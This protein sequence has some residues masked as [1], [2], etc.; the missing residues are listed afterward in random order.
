MPPIRW[1]ARAIASELISR[2]G[3]LDPTDK[4][5]TNRQ[6]V[7][8]DFQRSIGASSIRATGFLLRNSL[9]LIL[10]LHLFSRRPAE[11]RPIR[12]GGTADCGGGTAHISAIGA[13]LRAAHR[14]RRRSTTPARLARSCRSLSHRC[15][16]ADCRQPVKTTSIRRWS[17]CM[18]RARSS[19][20]GSS[21][22]R[23]VCEPTSTSSPSPR[24]TR[25]TPAMAP[26]D[27]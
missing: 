21:A 26:T 19:G 5:T 18:R 3:T 16:D 15:A 22:Q 4:G 1:P 27:S 13:F 9:N 10:E 20:R 24:R 11:R 6:S 8:A 25:S 23:W 17:A 14:E 7:T 2:F 12:A